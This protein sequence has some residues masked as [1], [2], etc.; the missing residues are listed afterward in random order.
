M[1][2]F[3][4]LKV[5]FEMEERQPENLAEI[6]LSR[7]AGLLQRNIERGAHIVRTGVK[8]D[9]AKVTIESQGPAI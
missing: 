8:P 1:K 9:S 3:A 4:R 7:E 6:V 5:E 2:C